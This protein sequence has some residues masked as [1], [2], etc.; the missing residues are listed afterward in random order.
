MKSFLPNSIK[1]QLNKIRATLKANLPQQTIPAII[2]NYDN[3]R[4]L[5]YIGNQ[6][7]CPCCEGHFRTFISYTTYG[8]KLRENAIC[9]RCPSVEKHRLL[10]LYL[11]NKTDLF[12]NKKKFC[13]LLLSI[14][15]RQNYHL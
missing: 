8:E 2:K 3:L 1:L 13:I 5:I 12:I 14:F 6:V 15:S 4:S 11:K 7:I 10:W 9:P